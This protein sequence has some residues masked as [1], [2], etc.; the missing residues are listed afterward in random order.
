MNT[1]G[2]V[3]TGGGLGILGS[4]IGF[5]GM[6]GDGGGVYPGQTAIVGDRGPE[7]L[8]MG[9]HGADVIPLFGNGGS[10]NY[11]KYMVP[12][13]NNSSSALAPI[14]NVH[15]HNPITLEDGLKVSMKAYDKWS[16]NKKV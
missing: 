11:T 8:K 14:V 9:T 16:N 5:I 15:I 3:T 6:L 4:I 12:S 2:G 1:E 7:L 10:M 13:F